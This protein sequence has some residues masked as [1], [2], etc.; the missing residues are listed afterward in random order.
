MK[1]R[2][3]IKQSSAAVAATCT[4]TFTHKV[5][6]H[7]ASLRLIH[8]TDCHVNG[9]QNVENELRRA[10]RK[11]NALDR[12]PDFILNGGDAIFDAMDATKSDTKIQ[13]KAWHTVVKEENN[14]PMHACIGNH[15]V[16]GWGSLKNPS[17]SDIMTGKQ[18]A[19]DE[20]GI[21]KR[22]YSFDY[23]NWHFIV[24]DTV[25]YKDSAYLAKLDEDQWAW[26]E[27]DLNE[28]KGKNVCILSHIPLLSFCHQIFLIGDDGKLITLPQGI[29]MN[30]EPLRIKNLIYKHPN[31]KLCLAG[32]LH[33]QEEIEYLNVKYL[34]NGAV[35]GNWWKGAFQEFEPAFTIVDLFPDGTSKHQWVTY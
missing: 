7:A 34:C 20:L 23:D 14:L 28:S 12:T 22:Y 16:F 10:F 8:L 2:L 18:W 35:S 26:L 29:L 11:I 32:H 6:E 27:K 13:W 3:F 5:N 17:A 19:M 15:D 4:S 9:D 33:M 21:A 31:V 30:S 24:L 25:Q 1:R